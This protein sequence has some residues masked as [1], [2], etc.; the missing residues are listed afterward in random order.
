LTKVKEEVNNRK[1]IK[2]CVSLRD[3]SDFDYKENPT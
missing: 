3:R 1:L 2:H